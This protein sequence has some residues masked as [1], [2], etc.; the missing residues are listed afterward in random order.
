MSQVYHCNDSIVIRSQA[1][2]DKQVADACI[3]LIA[4][5]LYFHRV[6]AT[7]G[8]PVAED[9]NNTMRAN[10]YHNRDEFVKYATAHFTMPTNNGGMYLEGYPGQT[11]LN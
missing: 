10:V 5:E 9:N 6:F 2:S 8:K 3:M 7:K 1:L 11:G 4:K